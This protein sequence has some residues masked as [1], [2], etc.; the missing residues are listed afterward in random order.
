MSKINTYVGSDG[1]IHFTNSAGADSALPFSSGP[2]TQNTALGGPWS[3]TVLANSISVVVCSSPFVDMTLASYTGC[4]LL[5]NNAARSGA[6]DG[7]STYTRTVVVKVDNQN[8]TV[9]FNH[10]A[11]AYG[12]LSRTSIL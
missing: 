11:A 1:K 9:T 5:Y 4:T 7:K 10:G 3:A 6:Y 8:R 12:T 2:S